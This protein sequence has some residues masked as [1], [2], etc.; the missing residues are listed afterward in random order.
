MRKC[1]RCGLVSPDRSVQCECG[2][3]FGVDDTA[4]VRREHA[5]W[6]ESARA[7][8]GGG[9]LLAGLGALMSILSYTQAVTKG[10]PYFIWTGAFIV[11]GGLAI[12]AWS[13]MRAIRRAEQPLDGE[14]R[15]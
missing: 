6:L 7:H 14:T 12:R 10:G 5:R 2:F 1:P 4:A 9:L 15:G 11:G 8:L 13:R 3:Q